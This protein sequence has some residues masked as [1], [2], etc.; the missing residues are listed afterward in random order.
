MSSK[1]SETKNVEKLASE[2]SEDDVKSSCCNKRNI[3]L[4]ILILFLV[5]L[6]FDQFA[7]NCNFTENDSQCSKR[8]FCEEKDFSALNEDLCTL[9]TPCLSIVF[10][11]VN[12]I[13]VNNAFLGIIITLIG[14]A[15]ATLA[16]IPGSLLSL[17]AAAA[18]SSAFGFFLGVVIATFCVWIG[19]TIGG[20][21][22]FLNGRYL[23]RNYA[24][25]LSE[26]YTII[27]SIDK[28]VKVNAFK[29]VLLLR[30]SPIIPFNIVNYILG[31]TDCTTKAY[32]LATLIG[33]LPGT[34]SFVIIGALLA[35]TLL[36]IPTT[37][38]EDEE[39]DNST[40]SLEDCSSKEADTFQLVLYILGGI[41]TIA[42]A[43]L[44]SKYSRNEWLKLQHET[45]ID[46]D[47][48]HEASL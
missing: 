22:A 4:A 8:L 35:E 43:L 39:F 13:L 20:T 17:G 47:K 23:L 10:A 19:A 30:L 27:K 32:F 2:T 40:F 15:I 37:G 38:Q 14:Y 48:D 29:V 26:K 9:K 45:E 34:I 5:F 44:L 25:K 7:P 41:I 11:S 46:N 31:G 28:A 36:G 21:L 12:E 42:I 3:L 16:M 18:F 6:M 24:E 1:V 33:I